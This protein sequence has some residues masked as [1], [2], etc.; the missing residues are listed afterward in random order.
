MNSHTVIVLGQIFVGHVFH[1]SYFQKTTE[2]ARSY[3]V[4]AL[5][6]LPDYAGKADRDTPVGYRDRV[7]PVARLRMVLQFLDDG[8]VG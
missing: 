8:G 7:M 5:A 1:F 6:R 4:R 3:A 2:L